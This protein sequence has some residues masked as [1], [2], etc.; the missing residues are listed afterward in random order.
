MTGDEIRSSYIQ[1]FES[2]GHLYMPS[3]S[4]IPAGDPTLLFTSAGMVPFKPFFMGEQTPPNRRLTSSQKSFRT[5]DIDEVG[6]HKH[7]TFFEMLGNFSIGDYFKNDAIAFAW[8]LVTTRFKLPPE[9][10]YVTIYLDDDEAFGIWRDE[11]GVP[12][13][14]IYR[15]GDSDNWWGP[16]GT[17][18]PTGPCSEIHYDGGAAKGCGLMVPPDELTAQFQ[19]ER[20]SGVSQNPPGCHPNCDCERFVELW[21]LVFMQY[22]QD[23]Q[24][25]RTPLPAPSVDTG[26]GLERAAAV[27]QDKPNVYETDIFWPIVEK[28]VELSGKP[29]GVDRET[30]YAL[31]VVAEHARAASFLIG[32]GVV[33]GNEGRGY[34]LRRVI[35][36]AI[37]YGRRLG[38]NGLFLTEVAAV[39]LERF[40]HVYRELEENHSFILRVIGL[41]EERFGQTFERGNDILRGMV[42]YREQVANANDAMPRLG[43]KVSYPS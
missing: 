22:Y 20:E 18:G 32:D 23:P 9:N 28:T 5:T 40:R 34:V 39:A 38:L 36:R 42:A 43:G 27:L 4:L 33:P 14:R 2:K 7:L 37:R 6:D 16:A 31:R 19:R 10:L 30:D 11:I 25:N 17:E 35:R 13:E 12:V 3:A 21:N 26:M 29:Y 1:F 8:E 24:R 15:Y 41:E